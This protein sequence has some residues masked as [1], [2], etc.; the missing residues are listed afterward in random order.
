LSARTAII[1]APSGFGKT[2]AGEYLWSEILP[3]LPD[4]AKSGTP[5]STKRALFYGV[6]SARLFSK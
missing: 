6:I 4:P 5:A 1:E 3:G 2:A